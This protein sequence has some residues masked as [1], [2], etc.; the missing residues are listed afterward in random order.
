[1]SEDKRPPEGTEQRLPD[2]PPDPNWVRPPPR[3]RSTSAA[4]GEAKG[5]MPLFAKVLIGIGA[6][7]GMGVISLVVVVL[8]ALATCKV[9]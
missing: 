1:M 6:I 4:P 3:P 2:V 8:S 5:G 7:I 9:R